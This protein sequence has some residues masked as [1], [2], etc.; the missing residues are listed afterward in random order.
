MTTRTEQFGGSTAFLIIFGAI[1][2]FLIGLVVWQPN[3]AIWIADAVERE[4]SMQTPD[5]SPLIK[6]ETNRKPIDPGEWAH[7]FNR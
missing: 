3:V 5:Q 2:V 4:R 6:L 1:F 7:V